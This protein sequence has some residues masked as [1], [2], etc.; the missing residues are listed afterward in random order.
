MYRGGDVQQA[1]LR[2]GILV[3][4]R[5]SELTG[6]CPMHLER[7]G[8]EDHNPS[9]SMNTET[10]VHHCFSCGY[11]GT[12]LTLVAEVRELKT[13][14]GRLDFEAAKDWLRSN[15]EI[16]F[17][18]LSKQLE[19]MR[20]TYVYMPKPIE[21]SE[22]RL[23]VFSAPPQWALDARDL[24][25]SACALHKVKWDTRQEAWI[26]PIR[27]PETKNLMGWQ[28]KGQTNRTFRN[29]P[30]GVVKSS[31]L[32]GIDTWGGGTMLVV[33]S[34]LDVVRLSSYGFTGAVATFGASISE[35]QVDLMRMADKLII[36]FDN[37]RIDAAGEKA[38]K[39]MFTRTKGSGLEC[40]FFN[41]SETES[42]DVG[43][44]PEDAIR[45]G[46]QNAKHCVFGEKAIYGG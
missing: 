15:V 44:M 45:L 19:E 40:W 28:E 17:E 29:R 11:K 14:W 26:T 23:A 32:F 20:N 38:S 42:K 7:T 8:K 18:L 35:A 21:M 34:P 39:D 24:A 6:Y 43:D 9:W 13:D 1:L 10:G 37:P 4:E 30:T 12:L 41:Y 25:D 33:E 31:T 36:A 16:D 2:M 27:N 3:E 22:A 5:N 46:I